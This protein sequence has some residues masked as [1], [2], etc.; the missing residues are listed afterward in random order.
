MISRRAFTASLIATGAAAALGAPALAQSPGI[1]DIRVDLSPLRAKGW[2]GAPLGVVDSTLRN[3]LRAAFA[4]RMGGGAVLIVRIDA[5]QMSGAGGGPAGRG[6]L[7]GGSIG[8]QTDY[9]EGE[10]LLVGRGAS[11]V[12]R[13]PML[14]ALAPTGTSWWSPDEELRRLANLASSYAYWARRKLG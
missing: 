1:G 11:V 9:M 12:A 6:R 14:S 4:D 5:I 8:G 10:L 2:G 7:S 13:E 3:G